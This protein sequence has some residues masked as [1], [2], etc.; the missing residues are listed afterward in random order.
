MRADMMNLPNAPIADQGFF[1][2]HFLTVQDQARSARFYVEILGGKVV[3]AEDP[4]YV[5]L[6]NSWI[7]LNSGGGPCPISLR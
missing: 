6:A 3:A 1:V 2:T 4:T 7:I 5:K